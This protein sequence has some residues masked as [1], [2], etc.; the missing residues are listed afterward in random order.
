MN[1]GNKLR[2]Y[3]RLKAK[4]EEKAARAAAIDIKEVDVDDEAA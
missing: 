2:A 1:L 3:P 4:A